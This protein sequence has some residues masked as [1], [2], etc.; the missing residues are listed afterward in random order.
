MTKPDH[1]GVFECADGVAVVSKHGGELFFSTTGV[2]G[3]GRMVIESKNEWW[4]RELVPKDDPDQ[5]MRSVEK[6]RFCGSGPIL[7]D[8]DGFFCRCDNAD[9]LFSGPLRSTNDDAITAWNEANQK[10]LA[11]ILEE[12]NE[13]GLWWATN[14]CGDWELFEVKKFD[15]VWYAR[16]CALTDW[17]KCSGSHRWQKATPR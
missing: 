17:Y 14:S 5:E 9:C 7:S 13:P 16:P 6:C 4:G 1:E 8:G 11:E 12:P 10:D 3:R 15:G 2:P